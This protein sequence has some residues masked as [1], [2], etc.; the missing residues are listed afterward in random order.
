[1]AKNELHFF[2]LDKEF[3]MEVLGLGRLTKND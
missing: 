2:N 3:C 1:M